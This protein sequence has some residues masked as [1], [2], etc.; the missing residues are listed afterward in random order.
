[1]II[2]AQARQALYN[3]YR[4]ISRDHAFD[5][6]HTCFRSKVSNALDYMRLASHFLCLHHASFLYVS[7]LYYRQ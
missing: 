5:H 2:K 1:M 3:I 6:Y 4:K 7:S